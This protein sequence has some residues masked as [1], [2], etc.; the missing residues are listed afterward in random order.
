MDVE[1]ATPQQ[2]ASA[3]L[4]QGVERMIEFGWPP[5]LA[6]RAATTAQPA[7]PGA[8]RASATVQVGQAAETRKSSA[9]PGA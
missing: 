7:A 3:L 4:A 2:D 1:H 9:R 6:R 8:T 5:D